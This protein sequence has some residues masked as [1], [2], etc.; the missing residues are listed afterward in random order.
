VSGD[1]EAAAHRQQDLYFNELF[2][3]KMQCEYMRRYRNILARRVRWLEIVRA[4]AASGAIATWAVFQKFPLIW[5]GIIAA[6][7]L[8]DALKNVIPFTSRNQAASG[9]AESLDALVIDA[10]YEWEGVYGGQFTIE[11]ITNRTRKLRQLR[12]EANVK[13]FP[14]EDLP[15]R[16]DLQRLAEADA[17]AY[18][19]NTFGPY[20]T[21]VGPNEQSVA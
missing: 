17:V 9:L 7:Q 3:L 1:N 19:E 21:A 10:L 8:L 2:Q 14:T 15:L 5:A 18:F 11:E 4:V 13:H 12:H 20:E 16:D 6:S